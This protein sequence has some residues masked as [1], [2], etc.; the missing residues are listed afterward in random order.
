M[1]DGAKICDRGPAQ[2]RRPVE[3]WIVAELAF[4]YGGLGRNVVQAQPGRRLER[5]LLGLPRGRAWHDDS[6][7]DEDGGGDRR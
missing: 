2:V 5:I 6:A 3:P 1:P 4:Q 7:G